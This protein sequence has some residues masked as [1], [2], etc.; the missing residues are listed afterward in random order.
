[1]IVSRERAAITGPADLGK[2]LRK[3]LDKED[4]VSS[5]KEHFWIII[6]NTRNRIKFVE[7]VSLG[8]LHA[9]LVHP[10]EVFRRAIRAGASSLIL[11]HNH[12]SGDCSP[13]DDDTTL[14]RR[15]T[16]AGRIIGIEVID[17]III[18]GNTTLSFKEKG[19]L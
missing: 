18:G 5:E 15:L 9:T 16:E 4:L 3:L 19:L 6:L 10:R 7:L 8:T 11:A 2:H 13:S 14:T 1:M 17:H 12:P